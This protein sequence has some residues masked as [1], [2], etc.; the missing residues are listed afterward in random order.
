MH[1]AATTPKC[2]II[3]IILVTL[4]LSGCDRGARAAGPQRHPGGNHRQLGR[5]GAAPR[6]RQDV[7]EK[8]Y[9]KQQ[10]L[11]PDPVD[12]SFCRKKNAENIRIGLR[13]LYISNSHC[14][15]KA[16]LRKHMQFQ[17]G[18]IPMLPDAS[19]GNASPGSS[20]SFAPG[21]P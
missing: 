18:T 19:C 3:R 16:L 12:L 14:A 7:D 20:W 15:R 17:H 13:G 5:C 4:A 6:P 2:I 1:G 8:K 10:S 11:G 21:L 9:Y